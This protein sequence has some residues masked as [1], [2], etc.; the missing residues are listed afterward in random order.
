MP[1]SVPREGLFDDNPWPEKL[2]ARVVTPGGRPR[3]HGYDVE[4]DLARHYRFTDLLLLTLT[5]E[6][7]SGHA[8]ALFDVA[9]Q[10]ASTIAVNEAPAHA[11]V[12]SRMCGGDA[13]AVSATTAI[14]LAEQARFELARLGSWL[15]WLAAGGVAIPAEA[16]ARDDADRESVRRLRNAAGPLVSH[17]RALREDTDIGR[18]AAIVACLHACGLHRADQIE[19]ALVTARL[20]LAVAEGMAASVGDFRNYPANLPRTEYVED[21]DEL[22]R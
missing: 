22:G 15:A 13:A 4:G 10:F 3:V 14:A 6:L 17:V 2:T 12:L 21:A 11:A 5:G 8:S 9:L 19:R 7:P 20:P 1:N 16:C 18:E